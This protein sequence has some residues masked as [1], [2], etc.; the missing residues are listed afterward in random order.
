ME[1]SDTHKGQPRPIALVLTAMASILGGA[2]IGASTNAIS[3]A[4]SPAYFRSV[5]RWDDV[6]HIWRASVAQGIFEGLVYG[7]LFSV[8]FTL[9]VGIVSRARCPFRFA[10]RHLLML[11]VGIYCCWAIGGLIAMGLATLSPEFYRNAFRGVPD[12]FGPMLCH[13]W[14]GGSIWGALWGGVLAA[15]IGSVL[16]SVHWRRRDT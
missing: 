15:A 7:L 2:L 10:L 16:F 4:V 1:A 5:M 11:A 8:V 9:V 12:G 14:V 6:E 3:G 13:A